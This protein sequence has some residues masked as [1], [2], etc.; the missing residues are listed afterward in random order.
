MQLGH[1]K[2]CLYDPS[3]RALR[4]SVFGIVFPPHTVLYRQRM[5]KN[6]KDLP[7]HF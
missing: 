2:S 6:L 4:P 3:K 1:P 5:T 7:I